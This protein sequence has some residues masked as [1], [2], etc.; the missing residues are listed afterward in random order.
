M[1]AVTLP[2][3]DLAAYRRAVQAPFPEIV[4]EL[5]AILGKKLTA[6]IGGV[7]DTRV[8]ERWMQGGVEPYRDAEQRVRL[9][10]RIA[11]TLSEHDSARVVQAWFVGLNPELGDRAPLRRLREDDLEKAGPELL[12]AMRAFLAGG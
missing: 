2:R 3:P 4:G 11:K 1:E 6:F 8:I 9:A 5:A 10:Y 12:N 7:K